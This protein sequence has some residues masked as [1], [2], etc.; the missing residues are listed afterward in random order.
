MDFKI[1][2]YDGRIFNCQ[3][4]PYTLCKVDNYTFTFRNQQKTIKKL[5]SGWI[6]VRDSSGGK[7]YHLLNN[8]TLFSK[9]LDSRDSLQEYGYSKE[10]LHN[11]LEK[12]IDYI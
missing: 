5:Q 2:L 3:H 6:F 11:Q 1:D 4:M 9:I 12:Y 7:R 10:F 8:I